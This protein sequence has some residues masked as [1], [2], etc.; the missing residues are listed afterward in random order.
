MNRTPYGLPSSLVRAGGVGADTLEGGA[1]NDVYIIDDVADVVVEALSSGDDV[2]YSSIADTTLTA[3]VETLYM[4]AG[5]KPYRTSNEKVAYID[6][7]TYPWINL[8]LCEPVETSSP[9][10]P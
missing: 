8:I 7:S 6:Q 2:V 5:L 1:G 9:L 4:T 3:N 10:D